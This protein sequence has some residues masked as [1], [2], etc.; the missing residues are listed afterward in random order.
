MQTPQTKEIIVNK[1]E[2]TESKKPI[3]VVVI[4]VADLAT[5]TGAGY[6]RHYGWSKTGR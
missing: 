1:T 6:T 3:D 4:Q 2:Q 5:V